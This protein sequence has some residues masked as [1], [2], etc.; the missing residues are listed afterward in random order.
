M[1]VCGATGPV[2]YD[3]DL[4]APR[5][6]NRY[7]YRGYGYQYQGY[8]NKLNKP[9][10]EGLTGAIPEY[11]YSDKNNSEVIN[12]DQYNNNT[13]TNSQDQE[14]SSIKKIIN[15]EEEKINT[16]TN[17]KKFIELDNK[18]DDEWCVI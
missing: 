2:G 17:V 10:I 13:N 12:I 16:M 18:D 7:A 6:S 9:R 1:S 15:I 5:T 14:N 3:E 4:E 11:Y 8:V